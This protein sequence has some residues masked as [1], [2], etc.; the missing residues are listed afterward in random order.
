MIA[1][2]TSS[3][4]IGQFL[5]SFYSDQETCLHHYRYGQAK[6]AE[7][8]KQHV[9]SARKIAQGRPIWVTEFYA[10]GTDD[11]QKLFLDS[12][13]PWMDS[14]LD[15][16]RYAY[17]MAAPGFLVLTNGTALSSVGTHFNTLDTIQAAKDAKD[18]ASGSGKQPKRDVEFAVL[19]RAQSDASP[20]GESDKPAASIIQVP[21]CEKGKCAI[22]NNKFCTCQPCDGGKKFRHA[23]RSLPVSNSAQSDAPAPKAPQTSGNFT[24]SPAACQRG[25][26]YTCAHTFCACQPCKN[27]EG[28]RSV[29]KP[30]APAPLL[31]R[32]FNDSTSPEL[33]PD[34]SGKHKGCKCCAGPDWHRI[35]FPCV[36]EDKGVGRSHRI[37]LGV[38]MK[39]VPGNMTAVPETLTAVSETSTPV[40]DKSVSAPIEK[41]KTPADPTD[42][43]NLNA[44]QFCRCCN[45]GL[46]W[47]CACKK[48]LPIGTPVPTPQATSSPTPLPPTLALGPNH[49]RHLAKRKKC[50]CCPK[51]FVKCYACQCGKEGARP[52]KAGG[53]AG[54]RDFGAVETGNFG[55]IPDPEEMSGKECR[56]AGWG[57]VC[58]EGVEGL[59]VEEGVGG[60][61][62]EALKNGA[63]GQVGDGIND[64]AG[65]VPDAVL[66]REAK[67]NVEK[68][69]SDTTRHSILELGPNA[70][71]DITKRKKCQCRHPGKEREVYECE[72]K[73]GRK[74]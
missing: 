4:Y 52:G 2:S 25:W 38:G 12:V 74:D 5:R 35:C 14:S 16:H 39:P 9:V 73:Y 62:G 33:A 23:Q 46:C 36:C 71:A 26:C 69:N 17:F 31:K 41:R 60:K 72:C 58:P 27:K 66:P 55:K 3:A 37:R 21:E 42:P 40:T 29:H 8:F 64:F 59:V 54:M 45:K 70:Q 53:R 32:Q 47:T 63:E 22:C 68:S 7:K 61:D 49:M 28:R 20:S 34:D 24:M 1:T 48:P 10:D 50:H 30:L 19:Q 57:W 65:T 44:R 11:E 18:K 43:N 56:F 15:I 6:D 67:D 13:L 51:M